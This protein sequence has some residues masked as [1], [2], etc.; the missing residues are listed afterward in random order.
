MI[1][2]RRDHGIV[3]HRYSISERSRKQLG[4]RSE[5]PYDARFAHRQIDREI[6]DGHTLKAQSRRPKGRGTSDAPLRPSCDIGGLPWTHALYF[7]ERA[8]V[9]VF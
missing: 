7:S 1:L 8:S 6:A 5:W 2:E 9:K 3:E 4:A